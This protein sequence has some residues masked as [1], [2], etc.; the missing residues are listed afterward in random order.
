MQNC[1]L[2]HIALYKATGVDLNNQE[3]KKKVI[4]TIIRRVVFNFYSCSNIIPM[5]TFI[6]HMV[7]LMRFWYVLLV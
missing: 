7:Q 5:L 2:V 4:T 1:P 3:N 6:R